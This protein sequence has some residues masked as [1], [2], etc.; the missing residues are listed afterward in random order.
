[1]GALA[2]RHRRVPADARPGSAAQA[3]GAPRQGAHRVDPPIRQHTLPSG[4]RQGTAVTVN[5][6]VPGPLPRGREGATATVRVTNPLAAVTSIHRH[7]LLVICPHLL[8][9]WKR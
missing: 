7:G 4:A 2:G 1:L 5:G 3:S 8:D 6:S 9:H